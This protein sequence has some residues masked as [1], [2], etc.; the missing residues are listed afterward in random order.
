MVRAYGYADRCERLVAPF[1]ERSGGGDG[2]DAEHA[3]DEIRHKSPRFR[4]CSAFQLLNS[5][6]NAGRS[7]IR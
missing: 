5:Q 2:Q 4:R 6:L 1:Q 7:G 3:D